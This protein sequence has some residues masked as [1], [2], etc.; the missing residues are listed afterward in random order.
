MSSAVHRTS[1]KEI[2]SVSQPS[3]SPRLRGNSE[4][5]SLFLTL[6]WPQTLLWWKICPLCVPIHSARL[7]ASHRVLKNSL[8]GDDPGREITPEKVEILPFKVM[9][10]FSLPPVFKRN[11]WRHERRLPARPDRQSALK[12]SNE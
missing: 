4:H 1:V 10:R 3:L 6:K 11:S 7:T 9:S 2:V 5:F 8:G 12:R